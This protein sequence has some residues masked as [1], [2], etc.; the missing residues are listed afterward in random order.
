MGGKLSQ[1]GVELSELTFGQQR[2]DLP[3]TRAT[4]RDGFL[5][6]FGF[7]IH[8]TGAGLAVAA[9]GDEVMPGEGQAGA[10]T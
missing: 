9:L 3:V 2:V 10:V 1:G 5:T 7:G 4:E 8:P 6:A